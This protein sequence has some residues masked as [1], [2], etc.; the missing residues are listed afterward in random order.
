[1]DRAERALKVLVVDDHHSCRQMTARLLRALGYQPLE[2]ADQFQAE[3][4]LNRHPDIAALVVDL[5]L[6]P[7]GDLGFARR[8]PV[9]HP[10]LPVLFAS[11]DCRGTC[12]ALGLTGSD[13]RFLE[14][15][16]ALAQLE[17]ALA[18]L[19]SGAHDCPGVARASAA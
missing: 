9:E 5:Y 13:R 15:P 11:G 6:D 16:F 7:T 2:A 8:L 14:K 19:L 3:S 4:A 1:M 18:E 17:A 12:E 10:G